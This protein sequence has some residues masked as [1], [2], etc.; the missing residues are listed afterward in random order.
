MTLVTIT[1]SLYDART[2][3]ILT[4]GKLYIKA[5]DFIING[6]DIVVPATVTYTIPVSGIISLSLSPSHGVKYT[7]EFDPNPADT[8][9]PRAMKSGYFK[10]RWTVP[11][12][13]PV[14]IASL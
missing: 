1:G 8:T 7:V 14:N 13:G 2:G 3:A 11:S 9:Q 6:N 12:S 10:D 5:D 4:A